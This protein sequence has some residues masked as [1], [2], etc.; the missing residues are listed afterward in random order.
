MS[1]NRVMEYSAETIDDYIDLI[2]EERR[3]SFR[4]LRQIFLESLPPGFEERMSYNMPSF[5]V[6]LSLYAPGYH[7]KK[8][9]PLP[10]IS[11]ACQKNFLALYHMGIYGDEELLNWFKEEYHKLS[12]GKLD[13]GKSCIRFKNLKKIPW[14]LIRDLAGKMTP[15]RMIELYEMSRKS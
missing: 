13:M 2:P 4:K 14:D 1:Y 6:P 3:G 5:V 12:I 9:E 11:L 8:E 10:F 7:C 15:Q